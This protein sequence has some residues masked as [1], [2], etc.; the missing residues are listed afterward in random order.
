MSTA[1]VKSTDK[2]A[3]WTEDLRALIGPLLEVTEGT[4]AVKIA[5]DDINSSVKDTVT[6]GAGWSDTMT[7]WLTDLNDQFAKGERAAELFISSMSSI[8]DSLLATDANSESIKRAIKDTVMNAAKATA[9]DT[10]MTA[11]GNSIPGLAGAGKGKTNVFNATGNDVA[12]ESLE[13]AHESLKRTL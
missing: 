7:E 10:I 5:I 4:A 11:L 9:K 6:F 1:L 12:V 13:I 2:T 8:V 3:A